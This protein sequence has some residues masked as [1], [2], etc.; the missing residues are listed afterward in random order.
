MTNCSVYTHNTATAATAA[1]A[2]A[3]SDCVNKPSCVI[4]RVAAA[5]VVV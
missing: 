1:A 4:A 2:A 5:A 3:V